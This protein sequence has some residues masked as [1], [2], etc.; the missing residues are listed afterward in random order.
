MNALLIA[1]DHAGFVLKEKLRR[2]LEQRGIKVKDLGTYSKE[3]CDYPEYAYSLAKAISLGQYKRGILICKS[4]IGNSI[5]AN[6]LPH[7]R[8]ALCHNLKIARLSRQHNDSNVLVLGSAFVKAGL[9]KKMAVAWL[10]TEF[11]GGRHLRRV[12]LINKI[13]QKIRR[14]EK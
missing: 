14:C 5:V 8:A 4:G 6:K 3:R 11:L 2:Y 1:S 9:A 10:K 7:V 12:K 13:E